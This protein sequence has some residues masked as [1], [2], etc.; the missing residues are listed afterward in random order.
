MR[1]ATSTQRGSAER[2]APRSPPGAG[3]SE[4]A[5]A[6]ADE[7]R[8]AGRN[9]RHGG[10]IRQRKARPRR[11]GLGDGAE[12]GHTAG[13]FHAVKAEGGEDTVFSFMPGPDRATRDAGG[14]QRMADPELHPGSE[15]T[16]L[17]GKRIV[18]GGPRRS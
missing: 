9:H 7:G 1:M 10:G 5:A 3:P 8:H 17:D 12:H 6:H 13:F 4:R 18:R 16:P 14:K 2:A 15:G 11:T